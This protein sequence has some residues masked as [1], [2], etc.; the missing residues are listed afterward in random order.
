MEN[1]PWRI[2]WREVYYDKIAFIGLL[3]FIFVTVGV[4]IG[5]LFVDPD[6]IM[7]VDRHMLLNRYR[8]PSWE[9][10]MGTDESGRNMFHMLILASRNSLN[11]A[12]LITLAGSSIGILVGLVA[13]FYG[14]H[15]DNFIMRILDF[16]AM[17]PLIML[18]ALFVRLLSPIDVPTF[19][20]L[21]IFLLGWQ[22]T[23]R[24]IRIMSL[25]QAQLD[26]VSASKTMGTPSVIVM[27]R[28]VLPNL[29]SI[30]ISN[31]TITLANFVGIET[32]LTFLGLGMPF[33]VPS[34]GLLVANA[35]NPYDMQNRMWL[36][37]PAALLIVMLMLSINF[38]GQALKRAADAR[39]RRV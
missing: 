15:V 7:R 1:S 12:F 4:Y 9:F 5:A 31:F 39:K 22:A 11:I 3:V 8:P 21:L 13:G 32:G 26:Y 20:M 35:I 33:N 14:G 6:I 25:R 29:V 23:A 17:L 28:E 34:L 18:V 30:I 27:F 36:W 2:M 38:V 10:I 16:M 37:L 19:S 24:L